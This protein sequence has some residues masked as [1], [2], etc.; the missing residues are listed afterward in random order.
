M[1]PKNTGPHSKKVK[2]QRIWTDLEIKLELSRLIQ[3]PGGVRVSTAARKFHC[4]STRILK[5]AN[6]IDWPIK[7]DEDHLIVDTAKHS[8]GGQLHLGAKVFRNFLRIAVLSNPRLGQKN[9]QLGLIKDVIRDYGPELDMVIVAGGLI[10]GQSRPG[11]ENHYFLRSFDEQI[12]YFVQNW[13]RL[14]KGK[15][16]YILNGPSDLRSWQ[17]VVE[18]LDDGTTSVRREPKDVAYALCEERSDFVSLGS[19]NNEIAITG[20]DNSILI[21]HTRREDKS[22]YTIGYPH[23]NIR[24]SLRQANRARKGAQAIVVC[25]YHVD[26]ASPED[27]ELQTFAVPSMISPIKSLDLEKRSISPTIGI[28]IFD[29][30]TAADQPFKLIPHFFRLDPYVTTNDWQAWPDVNKLEPDLLKVVQALEQKGELRAGEIARVVLQ[31][32]TPYAKTILKKLL[33]DSIIEY[34]Y[35]SRL[36]RLSTVIRTSWTPVVEF[37]KL[38]TR[39]DSDLYAADFH[40]AALT[41]HGHMLWD[42]LKVARDKGIKRFGIAGDLF[43][44]T[45]HFNG[46]AQEICLPAGMGL[47]R[48]LVIYL[49]KQAKEQ[50]LLDGIEWIGMIS[51]QHDQDAA[52]SDGSGHDDVA[53]LVEELNAQVKNIFEYLGQNYGS[54]DLNGIKVKMVHPS[55]GLPKGDT[56]RIQG[57]IEDLNGQTDVLSLD[58]LHVPTF[59]IYQG[60]VGIQCGAFKGQDNYLAAKGKYP[61]LGFWTVTYGRDS[62]G[63]IVTVSPIFWRLKPARSKIITLT[64]D[65]RSV[66]LAKIEYKM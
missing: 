44:G 58:H 49:F 18:N 51:G 32:E 35:L 31:R 20:T 25:G 3:R 6:Q 57:F 4:H 40:A 26:Y 29:V 10:A 64:A 12:D 62:Q 46:H 59:V 65:D 11:E 56:Y 55:G 8:G 41:E 50:G 22:I 24:N 27:A 45:R 37:K 19:Y 30:P 33:D 43:E 38:I 21:W 15:K 42:M 60:V 9:Q 14:P 63:N 66:H 54:Y 61:G 52:K 16:Y 39:T 23:R 17:T 1:T 36:Y 7:L 34:D 53:M 28:T 47:Q 2:K 5:I 13:P 48:E